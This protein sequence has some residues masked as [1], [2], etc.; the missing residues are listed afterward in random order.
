[1]STVMLLHERVDG[2]YVETRQARLRDVLASRLH[3][4]EL[5]RLLAAGV[6]PETSIPLALRARSLTEPSARV[7]LGQRLWEVIQQAERPASPLS[8]AMPICNA[9]VKLARTELLDLTWRLWA[10]GAVAAEGVARTRLLL[11]DGVSPL[12]VRPDADDLA[13]AAEAA[14][15]ALDPWTDELAETSWLIR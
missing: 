9:K 1:M 13:V 8:A 15:L 5:D 2:S 7:A 12:Y 11:C 4:G 6:S 3:A 10:A 14:R